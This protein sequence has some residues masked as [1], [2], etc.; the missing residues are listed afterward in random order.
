M[1]EKGT[2]YFSTMFLFHFFSKEWLK[3]VIFPETTIHYQLFPYSNDT[4][5]GN[6]SRIPLHA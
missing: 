4:F 6:F 5:S 1:K 3:I 2:S